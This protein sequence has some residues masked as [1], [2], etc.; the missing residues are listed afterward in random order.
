MDDDEAQTAGTLALVD[1]VRL[2]KLKVYGPLTPSSFVE[3]EFR[4][5]H[6]ARQWGEYPNMLD[7]YANEGKEYNCA[8]RC[9]VY[10]YSTSEG[11]ALQANASNVVASSVIGLYRYFDEFTFDQT[12]NFYKDAVLDASHTISFQPSCAEYEL[13]YL[14]H[15]GQYRFIGFNKYFEVND[16]NDLIGKVNRFATSLRDGQGSEDVVGYR[17]TRTIALTAEAISLDRLEALSELENSPKVYLR[18]NFT[19]T[20]ADW[21]LTRVKGKGLVRQAKQQ[22]TDVTYLVEYPERYTLSLI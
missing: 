14:D 17:N 2:F 19:G 13:R 6:G 8:N 18:V 21:I 12:I 1:V 11:N 20:A 3:T 16:T 4:G 15:N 10:Y 22:F 5:C 7:I 9:Y